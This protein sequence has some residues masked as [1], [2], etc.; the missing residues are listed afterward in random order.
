MAKS[1]VTRH[2]AFQGGTSRQIVLWK[3]KRNKR[4]KERGREEEEGERKGRRR[5]ER[6]N[7]KSVTGGYTRIDANVSHVL[8]INLNH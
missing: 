5:R 7:R 8:S 3:G 6:T 4:R 2:I 1:D